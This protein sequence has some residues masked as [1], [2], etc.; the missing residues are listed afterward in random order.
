M[1]GFSISMLVY[2]RGSKHETYCNCP[3][4]WCYDCALFRKHIH[5]FTTVTTIAWLTK[6]I[7]LLWYNMIQLKS[8]KYVLRMMWWT[9][10]CTSEHLKLDV[11]PRS[12]TWPGGPVSSPFSLGIFDNLDTNTTIFGW[13]KRFQK[14]LF[15]PHF[16]PWKQPRKPAANFTARSE[17]VRSLAKAAPARIWVSLLAVNQGNWWFLSIEYL[18]ILCNSIT[19]YYLIYS[20]YIGLD[21]ILRFIRAWITVSPFFRPSFKGGSGWVFPEMKI[22]ATFENLSRPRLDIVMALRGEDVAILSA[23]LPKKC[24]FR[25]GKNSNPKPLWNWNAAPFFG[26]QIIWANVFNTERT[27]VNWVCDTPWYF[28]ES[29][30]LAEYTSMMGLEFFRTVFFHVY[31]THLSNRKWNLCWVELPFADNVWDPNRL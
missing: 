2:K 27:T 14:R 12:G 19:E 6:N 31:S 10:E 25:L 8:I 26:S 4:S 16:C 7:W 13:Q 22:M 29:R 1:L 9:S 24:H 20:N 30:S 15:L 28:L 5:C 3:I 21:W 23:G 17:P 18:S 11:N